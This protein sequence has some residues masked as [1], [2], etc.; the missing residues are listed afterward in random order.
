MKNYN[1]W[2]L[3]VKDVHTHVKINLW[4]VYY[5]YL[6]LLLNIIKSY[7]IIDCLIITFINNYPLFRL[8]LITFIAIRLIIT[9]VKFRDKKIIF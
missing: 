2:I 6:L 8:L 3:K 9:F 1:W 5:T 7:K 4:D